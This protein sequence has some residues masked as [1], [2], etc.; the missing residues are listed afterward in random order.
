MFPEL[1]IGNISNC[2]QGKIDLVYHN[3]KFDDDNS[4]M[5]TKTKSKIPRKEI[6]E[7]KC[8]RSSLPFASE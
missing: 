7:N 8:G 2:P 1:F 5:A 3:R 4:L 6:A